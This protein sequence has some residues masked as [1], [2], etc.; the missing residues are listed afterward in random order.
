MSMRTR[1]NWDTNLFHQVRVNRLNKAVAVCHFDEYLEVC[2]VIA[3]LLPLLR[4]RFGN[5]VEVWFTDAAK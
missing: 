1:T 5:C 2:S 3:N 4:Q